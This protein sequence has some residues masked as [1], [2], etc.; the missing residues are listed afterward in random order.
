MAAPGTGPQD[1][2]IA[3]V[4]LVA[5]FMVA[6]FAGDWVMRN[7]IL[8]SKGKSARRKKAVP[9]TAATGVV[10]DPQAKVNSARIQRDYFNFDHGGRRQ[11]SDGERGFGKLFGQTNEALNIDPGGERVRE[12]FK[13][14]DELFIRLQCSMG[15]DRAAGLHMEHNYLWLKYRQVSNVDPTDAFLILIQSLDRLMERERIQPYGPKELEWIMERY[16]GTTGFLRTAPGINFNRVTVAFFSFAVRYKLLVREHHD[17]QAAEAAAKA[18]A[19]MIEVMVERH[20]LPMVQGHYLAEL[21]VEHV[22]SI[23]DQIDGLRRTHEAAGMADPRIE[24]TCHYLASRLKMFQLRTMTTLDPSP[25]RVQ[26]MHEAHMRKLANDSA[27][28]AKE[29]LKYAALLDGK[30]ARPE[31]RSVLAQAEIVSALAVHFQ[32]TYG[33]RHVLESW[34]TMEA[35]KRL[36]VQKVLEERIGVPQELLVS[37]DQEWGVLDASTRE[38]LGRQMRRRGQVQGEEASSQVPTVEGNLKV[39]MVLSQLYEQGLPRSVCDRIMGDLESTKISRG[40]CPRELRPLFRSA[41]TGSGLDQI[42]LGDEWAGYRPNK[43]AAVLFRLLPIGK[44]ADGLD[45][46]IG[47]CVRQGIGSIALCINFMQ[48]MASAEVVRR[49]LAD[50]PKRYPGVDIKVFDAKDL[51]SELVKCL[52]DNGVTSGYE[53]AAGLSL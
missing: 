39:L 12:L 1:F 41:S 10:A 25:G 47:T 9:E 42:E 34:T 48:D 50:H 7:G 27:E 18:M 46:A 35:V 36:V 15:E 3:M 5:V 2:L 8:R 11:Q 26:E 6:V 53:L 17:A 49:Y 40:T 33:K 24:T 44:D 31:D 38:W 52:R 51:T 13:Q 29:A 32:A 21:K 16:E 30:D 20:Y 28:E 19:R 14:L 23:A 22:Q 43:T 45:D 37:C 4:I